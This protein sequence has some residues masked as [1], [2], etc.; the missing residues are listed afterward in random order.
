MGYKWHSTGI[1]GLRY[2]EHSSR[3]HG[4]KRDRYYA[5]RY[6]R[7]GKRVEGGLGWTSDE[8]IDLDKFL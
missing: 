7:D 5:I 2:R 1:K 8:G 6:Q 3:K 4:V